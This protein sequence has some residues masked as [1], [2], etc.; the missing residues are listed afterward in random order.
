MK[1]LKTYEQI[2]QIDNIKDYII[3]DVENMNNELGKLT[4]LKKGHYDYQRHFLM[5]KQQYS[6]VEDIDSTFKTKEHEFVIFDDD[7]S[8]ILYTSD[9][10]QDCM[11]KLKFIST[12]NKFNI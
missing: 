2:E 11:D 8:S 7:K 6:Y 9:D 1:H 4:I 10:L 12:S 5:T 3:F